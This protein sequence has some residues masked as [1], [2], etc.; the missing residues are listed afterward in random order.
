LPSFWKSPEAEGKIKSKSDAE[1]GVEEEAEG[2]KRNSYEEM[3]TFF[4]GRIK[5]VK[6]MSYPEREIREK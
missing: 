5:K 6:V 3:L 4:G 1:R 2:A